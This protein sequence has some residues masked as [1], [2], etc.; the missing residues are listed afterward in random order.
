MSRS[1]N[2]VIMIGTIGKDAET[3]ST[4]GG[5]TVSNFSLATNRRVKDSG[6][7]D[8]KEETDWHNIVLWNNDAVAQYLQKGKQVYLEG[9][10][11]TRSYDDKEGN[12]RYVTEIMAN[13]IVLLGGGAKDSGSQAPSKPTPQRGPTQQRQQQPQPAAQSWDNSTIDDDSV[14]F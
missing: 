1:V 3:K 13:E 7:G 4:S 5:S 9:S 6:S 11:R 2:K 8:Y 14:P 10:I 12:K